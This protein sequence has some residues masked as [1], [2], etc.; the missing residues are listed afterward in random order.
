MI[1]DSAVVSIGNPSD[2]GVSVLLEF[3]SRE[4]LDGTLKA[5]QE[6]FME[7]VDG[8]KSHLKEN[9]LLLP[10]LPPPPSLPAQQQDLLVHELLLAKLLSQSAD[11]TIDASLVTIFRKERDTSQNLAIKEDVS[12]VSNEI[13]IST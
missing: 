5:I 13:Q 3:V 4:Y 2:L 1:V 9:K 6:S 7:H 10:T 12:M 11:V 8:L